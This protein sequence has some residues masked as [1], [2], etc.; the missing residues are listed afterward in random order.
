MI[1]LALLHAQQQ[2]ASF[3]DFCS[4]RPAASC[5]YDPTGQI[6]TLNGEFHLA[7]VFLT[8]SHYMMIYILNYHDGQ[9][10]F[11]LMTTACDRALSDTITSLI[12]FLCRALYLKV[13]QLLTSQKH[14]L[15]DD[16][17]SWHSWCDGTSN[18]L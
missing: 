9:H 18:S 8:S 17:F 1:S 11:T 2:S 3:A 14:R 12:L 7:V 16:L 5:G 4:C 15:Q 10:K 13:V 6:F